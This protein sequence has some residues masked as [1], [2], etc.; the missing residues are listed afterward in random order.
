MEPAGVAILARNG[1]NG[2]ARVIWTVLSSTFFKPV[3]VGGFCAGAAVVG[4]GAVVAARALVAAGAVVACTL[5][6]LVGAAGAPPHAASSA[7]TRTT[8]PAATYLK[9]FPCITS[10]LLWVVNLDCDY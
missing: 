8:K 6:T 3:T 1:A 2:A 5:G 10:P 4:C 7:S 9:Y